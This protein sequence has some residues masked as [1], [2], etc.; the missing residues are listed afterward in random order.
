[1]WVADTRVRVRRP[2]PSHAFAK[3]TCRLVPD[4][5]TE[6]IAQKVKRYIEEACPPEVKLMIEIKGGGNPYV[7]MPPHRCH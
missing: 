6:D 3:I 4:Q 2:I 1:M 7:V 5:D